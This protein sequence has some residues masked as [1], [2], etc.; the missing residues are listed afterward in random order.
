MA[1]RAFIWFE[2]ERVW[3]CKSIV[4]R[5]K[6]N[7]ES[8][9]CCDQC[10]RKLQSKKWRL[11]A[12]TA[13]SGFFSWSASHP[14]LKSPDGLATK[15]QARHFF[16]EWEAAIALST[17]PGP[18]YSN[19]FQS[20]EISKT[21]QE[22]MSEP[23]DS[24]TMDRFWVNGLTWRTIWRS[25]LLEPLEGEA[26][27]GRT[28]MQCFLMNWGACRPP[29]CMFAER[30]HRSTNTVSLTFACRP[31]FQKIKMFNAWTCW[32]QVSYRHSGEYFFIKTAH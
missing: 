12:C 10:K 11:Q 18:S 2:G 29:I 6:L 17:K 23:M 32:N 19:A 22:S 25:C 16:F 27:H 28:S 26:L 5:R 3:I 8:E 1:I 31:R 13:S 14:H 24:T 9:T 7:R 20:W 21:L 15:G 30:Y 4:D